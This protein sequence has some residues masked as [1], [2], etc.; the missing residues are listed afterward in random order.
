MLM[1]GIQAWETL[2]HFFWGGGKKEEKQHK[3]QKNLAAYVFLPLFS[4]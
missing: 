3:I 4:M 2:I 1:G